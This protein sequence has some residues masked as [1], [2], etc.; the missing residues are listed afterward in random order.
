[1][2]EYLAEAEGGCV[3]W[4]VERVNLQGKGMRITRKEKLRPAGMKSGW[5]G[6]RS[7]Q[8]KSFLPV[9]PVVTTSIAVVNVTPVNLLSY[10]S[11]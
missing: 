10:D 8:H 3:L 11:Q 1:M 2:P 4:H 6:K 7:Y 9:L 5:A